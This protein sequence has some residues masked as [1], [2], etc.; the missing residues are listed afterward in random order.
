MAT[1][2]FLIGLGGLILSILTYFAGVLRTERR[3]ALDDRDRRITRVLDSY[4]SA[5]RT[6]KTNGFPGLIQAGVG[7]LKDES[8]INSLF[9]Q[10]VQ[11]REKFDPRKTL[12]G[13]NSY[14]FFK[15]AAHRGY[16]FSSDMEVKALV[17]E[18]QAERA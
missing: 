7:T 13:V 1:N 6:G 9:E 2:E 3:H 8:E 5:A 12:E 18:L 10:L 11:H 16:T 17:E 14:E 15:V 4:L